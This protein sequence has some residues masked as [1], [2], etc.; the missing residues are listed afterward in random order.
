MGLPINFSCL[1][2][3]YLNVSLSSYYCVLYCID[4]NYVPDGEDSH[5]SIFFFHHALYYCTC[6]LIFMHNV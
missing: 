4:L 5:I 1:Y 6:H 3:L 2:F